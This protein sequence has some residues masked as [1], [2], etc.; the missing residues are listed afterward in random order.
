MLAY[1]YNLPTKYLKRKK[2]VN[3]NY[4]NK[5]S[6]KVRIW[7]VQPYKKNYYFL[8][9]VGIYNSKNLRIEIVIITLLL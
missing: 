7:W 4:V 3:G 5:Q 1:S 2:F 6:M 8:I 9:D